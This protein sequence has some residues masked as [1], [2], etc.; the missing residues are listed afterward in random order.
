MNNTNSLKT[1]V[2]KKTT[3]NPLYLE[4]QTSVTEGGHMDLPSIS[5]QLTATSAMGILKHWAI[6]SSSTSKA[7][8]RREQLL[9]NSCVTVSV[10]PQ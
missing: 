8:R 10:V 9:V 7:L 5:V 6:Y 2:L 3:T 4:A 1:F